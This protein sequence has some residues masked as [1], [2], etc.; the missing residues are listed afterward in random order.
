MIS[1]GLGRFAKAAKAASN[2]LGAGPQHLKFAADG[3]G[4]GLHVLQL[5]R[6][7]RHGGIDQQPDGRRAWRQLDQD[8]HLFASKRPGIECCAGDVSLRLV[9]A[10]DETRRHR[11]KSGSEHDRNRSGCRDRR[12]RRAAGND[13][14]NLTGYQFGS[15]SGKQIIAVIGVAKFNRDI[16]AFNITVLLETRAE[17]WK[18]I[19]RLLLG[20]AG[21]E[22]NHRHRGSL[23]ARRKRP[24]DRRAAEKP[25]KFP[26]PHQH[27]PQP[28]RTIPPSIVSPAGGPLYMKFECVQ[29][30]AEASALPYGR[31]NCHPKL[32]GA[33]GILAGGQPCKCPAQ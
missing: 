29:D 33:I 24:R 12:T 26:P 16:F 18:E 32:S 8:F 23:R 19:R 21:E 4:R 1:R 5:Y 27:H 7:V 3:G 17:A 31:K 20:T 9:E 14:R 11:I 22:S 2:S 10:A 30:R 6:G 15:K 25:D 28:E 13:H